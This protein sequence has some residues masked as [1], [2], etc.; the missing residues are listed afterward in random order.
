LPEAAVRRARRR[1]AD[2]RRS[3]DQL[4]AILQ[5]IGEGVTVQDQ[6]GRLVYA[7]EEAAHYSG[8]DSTEAFLSA[9]I[10]AILARFALFEESGAPFDPDD[11]PGQRVLRGEPANEV[12]VQVHDRHTGERRWSILR[13]TP[14]HDETGNLQLVVNIFRDV[15]ER[16]RLAIARDFLAQASAVLSSSLDAETS[17]REVANLAVSSIADWCIVD[18]LNDEG[19]VRRVTVA[20]AD[21]RHAELAARLRAR[22]PILSA[23]DAV[24]RVLRSGRPV[25]IPNLTPEMIEKVI[26]HD[27]ERMRLVREVAPRSLIVAAVRARGRTLGAITLGAVDPT[28]RYDQLELDVAD[29]LAAR[30]GLA[31]DN[32]SLYRDAQEQ[33]EHQSML[34]VA[35]REA[36][37]ERDRALADLR[38]ALRTRDDFLASASH[39]LKNPLASIK[40]TAQL[41]LRRLDRP[42]E[43]EQDLLREGL[44]RVDVVATRAAALVDELLDLARMQMGRPLALERAPT[45]LVALAQSVA[46]EHQPAADL[47]VIRVEFT[48]P[49][50]V[51]NW[52][53]RRLRRV[54]A[55]LVDNAL[56]YSPEGGGIWFRVQP[57]GEWVS[58]ELQDEGIGIPAAELGRVFE[59]FQ[60]ASNVEGR[61]GGTGIGLASARH[62]VESHGGSISVASAEGKGTTFTIKLPFDGAEH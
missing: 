50:V 59:R 54:L 60:R 13:S 51:G 7:N 15:T 45:D 52:D 48:A 5:G 47:H 32:A 16:K 34:N 33:A 31:L 55:N 46:S 62:I 29:E 22:N 38:Q 17:L 37:E 43:S 26:A 21:P 1:Q 28:Q 3:R 2:L 42:A 20:H 18:V 9:S 39:D 27:P 24:S 57:A 49:Q 41:L 11:L 6:R 8:F 19:G 12:I 14:V 35:L 36:V 4:A 30:V 61:I 58:L 44:D 23:R 56:K 40:A 53:A 25:L 10:D